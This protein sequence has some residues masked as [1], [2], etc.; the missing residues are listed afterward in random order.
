MNT[1]KEHIVAASLDS[2][3]NANHG[4]FAQMPYLKHAAMSW[5]AVI[6]CSRQP[7]LLLFKQYLTQAEV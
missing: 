3:E 2:C 5:I 1:C 6:L 7:K 4:S